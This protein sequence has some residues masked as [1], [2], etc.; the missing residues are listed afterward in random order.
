MISLSELLSGLF[1]RADFDNTT[2]SLPKKCPWCKQERPKFSNACEKC[3]KGCG[4]PCACASGHCPCC[5]P[6]GAK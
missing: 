2:G 1:W 5:T 6:C 4:D 3:D